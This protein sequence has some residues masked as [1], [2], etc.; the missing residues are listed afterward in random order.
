MR[1]KRTKLKQQRVWTDEEVLQ[2]LTAQGYVT[3]AELGSPEFVGLRPMV[4]AWWEARVRHAVANEPARLARARERLIA[5]A[6]KI[7]QTKI[8]WTE[9]P[10]SAA[11]RERL[12]AETREARVIPMATAARARRARRRSRS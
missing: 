2:M 11:T 1:T 7:E 5:T 8:E 6:R 12:V 3:R 10:Q 9:G 4:D